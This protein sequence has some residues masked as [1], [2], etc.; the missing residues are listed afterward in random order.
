MYRAPTRHYDAWIETISKERF[1]LPKTFDDSIPA[2]FPTPCADVPADAQVFDS[3]I[4]NVVRRNGKPKSRW[5]VDGSRRNNKVQ[6]RDPAASSP[7]YLAMSV[8]LVLA[9][10]AKFG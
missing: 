4:T 5:V 3:L 7:T 10:A 8:F 6:T 2:F 9:L 1:D